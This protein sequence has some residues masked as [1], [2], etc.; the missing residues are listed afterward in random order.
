MEVPTTRCLKLAMHVYLLPCFLNQR[1]Q[2]LLLRLLQLLRP[3]LRASL[4]TTLHLLPFPT[5]MN[6][7]KRPTTKFS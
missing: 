4:S 3:I 2:F 7:Q 6:Y 1:R 5:H